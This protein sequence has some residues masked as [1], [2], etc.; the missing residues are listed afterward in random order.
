[1]R[2]IGR[3]AGDLADLVEGVGIDELVDAFTNGVP[4][5][6][7]L[8]LYPLRTTELFGKGFALLELVQFWLPTHLSVTPTL[9]RLCALRRGSAPCRII[10]ISRVLCKRSQPSWGGP[11]SFPTYLWHLSAAH[12]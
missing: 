5:T 6:V 3:Q 12:G 8:P 10:G 2:V 9:L 4:A 7:M 11:L 1:M